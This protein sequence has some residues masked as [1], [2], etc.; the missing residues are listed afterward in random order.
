MLS[1]AAL[2]SREKFGC[3]LF[4]RLLAK[5]DRG[6]D[7]DGAYAVWESVSAV[8]VELWIRVVGPRRGRRGRGG[9]GDQPSLNNPFVVLL[10]SAGRRPCH[11]FCSI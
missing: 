2:G 8:L 1:E 9:T 3:M 11:S 6:C 5:K 4:P 10:Q 7:V